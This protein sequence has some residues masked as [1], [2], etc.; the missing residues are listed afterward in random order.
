M[1]DYVYDGEGMR[2][3]AVLADRT[4]AKGG[5][6]DGDIVLGIGDIEVKDIYSYMEGLAKFKKGDKTKIVVK[7]GKEMITKEALHITELAKILQRIIR[8]QT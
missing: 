3:D 1:P 7:R 4:A 5:L 6:E 2:I 8:S